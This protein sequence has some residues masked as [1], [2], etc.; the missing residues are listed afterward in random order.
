MAL[1]GIKTR[2]VCCE[3]MLKFVLRKMKATGGKAEDG[4]E[5]GKALKECGGGVAMSV[6]GYKL[7]ALKVL[8]QQRFKEITSL[9]GRLKRKRKRQAE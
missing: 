3:N 5:N 2:A 6:Q 8:Y 9:S 1:H 4:K 7:R